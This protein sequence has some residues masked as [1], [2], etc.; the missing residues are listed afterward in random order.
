LGWTNETSVDN[1]TP[2]TK[3]ETQSAD[4]PWERSPDSWERQC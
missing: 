4:R 1:F 3:S 2:R